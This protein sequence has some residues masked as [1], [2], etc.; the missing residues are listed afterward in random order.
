M[1]TNH[2][3]LFYRVAEQQHFTRAAE[4]L[5]IS[6]PAVS[7]QVKELEKE[8]G[9]TLFE[10]NT[11]RKVQ[12]TEVGQI[13]YDY[14]TQIFGQVEE[15]EQVINEIKGLRRG[16]LAIGAT[17][18][19]G[20]YLLPALLAQFKTSYPLID[21]F[22]DIENNEQ[23]QQK[24]L[25]HQLELGLV[26]GFVEHKE[27]VAVDWK[28]DELVPIAAPHHNLTMQ[29]QR[30]PLTLAQVLAYPLI[31]R[32]K[33]SGTRDVLEK[34]L[35]NR[36]EKWQ[37]HMELGS[38]EAIKRAVSAGLGISFVSNSTIEL[39]ELTGRLVGLPISDFKLKRI[40]CLI[41]R[42]NHHFSPAAQA[43]LDLMNIN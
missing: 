38:T 22:L 13:L 16:R 3:Y 21:L 34:A 39:E 10:A 40:L 2:L 5:F 43:L 1:N 17:T 20:I 27:L 12:L 33:G 42:P 24:V 35:A 7:K 11:R 6:Q 14:A 36:P 4:E 29:S 15:V 30:E 37:M 28:P 9:V 25:S 18:T 23:I 26:E 19:I 32:E 8:L 31:L 41:H